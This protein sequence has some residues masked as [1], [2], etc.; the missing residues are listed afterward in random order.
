MVWIRF[1][2]NLRLLV[3][4]LYDELFVIER[5]VP[6]LGPREADFGTQFVVLL[7]Y[8]QPEGVHAQVEFGALFVANLEILKTSIRISSTLNNSRQ[9]IE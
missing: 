9:C 3:H 5:D 6:D 7:V 2:V 4:R 8:V 1:V